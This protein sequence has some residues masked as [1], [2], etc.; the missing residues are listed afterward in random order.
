MLDPETLKVIIATLRETPNA[1]AQAIV[2]EYDW[3]QEMIDS[4]PLEKDIEFIKFCKT[5][6]AELCLEDA[7]P[8]AI[9]NLERQHYLKTGE[10]FPR[11]TLRRLY[12]EP[13]VQ[14]E[15]STQPP[16]SPPNP[17]KWLSDEYKRKTE[18]GEEI[19]WHFYCLL[20]PYLKNNL[21]IQ[22]TSRP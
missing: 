19:S 9:A 3:Y 17:P 1:F 12:G 5:Q 8:K 11:D 16:V 6:Q 10:L 4:D 20:Y 22:E 21:E 15:K 13:K 7:I 14:I 18:A 2:K